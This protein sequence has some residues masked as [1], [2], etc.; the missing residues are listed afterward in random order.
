M[1]LHS[2]DMV[3]VTQ[4]QPSESRWRLWVAW[5]CPSWIVEEDEDEDVQDMIIGG[6]LPIDDSLNWFTMQGEAQ[7]IAA[8][9]H[10]LY[11]CGHELR[12]KRAGRDPWH[13]GP[14]PPDQCPE[15]AGLLRF[16]G[17][18][19][20]KGRIPL[21]WEAAPLRQTKGLEHIVN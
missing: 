2:D 8:F 7:T 17:P 1:S 19:V 3:H 13:L 14:H 21:P 5:P 18:G 15:M 16:C 9:R 20:Y 4:C 12:A 11:G 10:D 6:Q